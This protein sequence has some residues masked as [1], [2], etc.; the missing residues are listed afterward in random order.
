VRPD[1]RL[2]FRPDVVFL[3]CF[4]AWF[5]GLVL[6][7]GLVS[8]FNAEEDQALV[9]DVEEDSVVGFLTFL[10]YFESPGFSL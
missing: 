9:V 1:L 7:V 2:F 6:L 3:D 5:S 4:E 10:S 8:V